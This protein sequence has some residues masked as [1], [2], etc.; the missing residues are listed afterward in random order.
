M[1]WIIHCPMSGIHSWAA[2]LLQR[3]WATSLVLSSVA[4]TA[5]LRG[6]IPHLSMFLTNIS[7][8]W[9]L[10]NLWPFAATGLPFQQQESLSWALLRES[11]PATPCQALAAVHGLLLPSKPAPHVWFFYHKISC[12]NYNLGCLWN[13]ASLCWLLRNAPQEIPPQWC[14]S[15]F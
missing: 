14:W 13:T 11:S 1:V 15:L 4:H 12:M 3:A 10:Q 8:Y 7:W 9:H 5:W 6:S 2:G